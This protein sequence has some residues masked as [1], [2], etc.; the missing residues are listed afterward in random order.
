MLSRSPHS[1]AY[2]PLYAEAN[3]LRRLTY[4]FSLVSIYAGCASSARDYVE[5]NF[6]D[7]SS[8]YAPHASLVA[9]DSTDS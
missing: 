3:V 1:L 6:L 8:K 2:L 4:S 7:V 9:N 5:V